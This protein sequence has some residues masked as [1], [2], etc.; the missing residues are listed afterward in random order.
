MNLNDN[1]FNK[2]EKKTKVNKDLILSLAEKLNKGK[3]KDKDTIKE[4][5]DT[6]S[7]V[8]GKPVNDETKEKIIAKIVKDEVPNNVDK[9]F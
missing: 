6:L 1:F 4:V 2:V 3:M 5:I 7:E 9:F 8:T